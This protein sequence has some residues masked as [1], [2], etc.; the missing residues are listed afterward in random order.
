MISTLIILPIVGFIEL[1]N[2]SISILK[3]LESANIVFGKNNSSFFMGHHGYLAFFTVISG[4]SWGLG[5]LGQPHLIIRYMAIR[6]VQDVKM[7]R[8]IAIAW[9]IPG[10]IGAFLIGIVSLAYFGPDYFVANDPE[11]SM[12][13]LA[14][15]LLSL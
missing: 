2:Q 10:V 3:T 11:K 5:Y 8:N 14:K 4:L 13:L 6:N 15:T 12:P 1:S 7:A 9:T